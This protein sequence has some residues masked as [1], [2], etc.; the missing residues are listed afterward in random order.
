MVDEFDNYTFKACHRNLFAIYYM[1][2]KASCSYKVKQFTSVYG[3]YKVNN[4]P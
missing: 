2:R 1:Q 3:G 4:K